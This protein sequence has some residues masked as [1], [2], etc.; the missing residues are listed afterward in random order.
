MDDMHVQ[1][2]RYI[3]W[4]RNI[5]QI[6]RNTGNCL[7]YKHDKNRIQ[8]AL[9]DKKTG[10]LS[11]IILWF[12]SKMDSSFAAVMFT[13]ILEFWLGWFLS[14]LNKNVYTENKKT[15]TYNY[16]LFLDALTCFQI[17]S[18]SKISKGQMLV[19]SIWT[20]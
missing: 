3:S 13:V 11:N 17:I 4:L 8:F 10:L 5:Y 12:I 20:T 16:T 14:Q 7:D 2:L 9:S 18:K 1:E 15:H 19:F 6:H